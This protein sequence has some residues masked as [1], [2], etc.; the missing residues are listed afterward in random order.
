MLDP[1]PILY[2]DMP[3]YGDVDLEHGLLHA[4]FDPATTSY[5]LIEIPLAAI[6]DVKTLATRPPVGEFYVKALRDGHNVPPVVIL[7]L[8]SGWTLIDGVNRT[9]ARWSLGMSHVQAY[10]LLT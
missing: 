2:R 1:G 10:E 8:A 4:G 6:A 5:R 7:R 9:H 3:L